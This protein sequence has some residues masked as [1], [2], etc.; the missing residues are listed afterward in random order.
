MKKI[1]SAVCILAVVFSFCACG[2]NLKDTE[3]DAQVITSGDIAA[4]QGK[5]YY[6]INGGMPENTK[7]SLKSD[8][9]SRIYR[10]N[11]D[12]SVI[13]EVSDNKA[14]N[15]HIFRDKIFYTSA[16]YSKVTLRCLGTDGNNDKRLLSFNDMDYLFYGPNGV[17]VGTDGKII[18]F[19]YST[20]KKTEY[21]TGEV[22]AI[23][24]SESYIYYYYQGKAALNRISIENSNIETISSSIGPFLYTDDSLVY[25]T[26]ARVPYRLNTNTLELVQISE[27]LYKNA[28]LNYKNGAI[29][30]VASDEENVGI[31]S[32]PMNNTAGELNENLR[33]KIN[34]TAVSAYCINDA[35]IF[36][37]EAET[38]DVYRMTYEG[39]EK[40]VLGN[41]SS[42]F[43]VDSI[44]V[45]D[46]MLFVFDSAE[47]GNVFAVPV[48]GSR[49]MI[50]A[51][52]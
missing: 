48:D 50:K 4:K 34:L 41:V 18:Y 9:R 32:Q 8:A 19:D 27:G 52:K 42:V 6:F 30:C 46:D 43:D 12:F 7:D 44:C 29:I 20:L 33:K 11:Y 51:V 10:A 37:V 26:Q 2:K 15:F 16:S 36:F 31:Y 49:A 13:E 38:G 5:W 23:S 40:T 45:T 3:P 22:T 17:A 25:F 39:T 47:N 28:I 24:I 14:H 1:I 35:Y 21:N